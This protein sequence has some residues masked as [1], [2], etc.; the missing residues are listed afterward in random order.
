MSRRNIV[1]I[2][3]FITSLW[4]LGSSGVYYFS[5]ESLT[6]TLSQGESFHVRRAL[7]AT[8][9]YLDAKRLELLARAEI[10]KSSK[11]LVSSLVQND[12]DILA[13]QVKAIQESW[14]QDS[15]FVRVFRFNSEGFDNIDA[16]GRLKSLLTKALSGQTNAGWVP[17]PEGLSLAAVIPI[18]QGGEIL[19]FVAYGYLISDEFLRQIPVLEDEGVI[20][21]SSDT[22]LYST[23]P[24]AQELMGDLVKKSLAADLS[25]ESILYQNHRYGVSHILDPSGQWLGSIF[26]Q[27]R[28]QLEENLLIFRS[29]Y[30]GLIGFGV[31]VVIFTTIV[32]SIGPYKMST[33]ISHM[34]DQILTQNQYPL[35]KEQPRPLVKKVLELIDHMS[36]DRMKV[37]IELRQATRRLKRVHQMLDISEPEF[38]VLHVRMNGL[39]D[40][41]DRGFRELELAKESYQLASCQQRCQV[42]I[43]AIKN[44]AQ[45]FQLEQLEHAADGLKRQL[46]VMAEDENVSSGLELMPVLKS[47]MER[48]RGIMIKYE[49]LREQL[50]GRTLMHA[51]KGGKKPQDIEFRAL[52]ED[53]VRFL[54][55]PHK[56]QEEAEKLESRLMDWVEDTQFDN[57]S[58]YLPLYW[59]LVSRKAEELHKEVSLVMDPNSD[60]Q[61]PKYHSKLINQVVVQ[62]LQNAIIH[63]IESPDVRRAHGKDPTG[64]IRISSEKVGVLHAITVTDDGGGIDWQKIQ[65]VAGA[66]DLLPEGEELKSVGDLI[67]EPGVSVTKEARPF[68]GLGLDMVAQVAKQ[69]GGTVRVS[70]SSASGVTMVFTYRVS[71]VPNLA[72]TWHSKAAS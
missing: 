45:T 12:P 37:Q 4:L 53:V 47:R 29:F 13:A 71:H 23:V 31:L 49:Q 46:K 25:S 30:F 2:V 38:Q 43:D 58:N 16:S 35:T 36:K 65:E 7:K 6:K 59:Q 34:I 44:Y 63:G 24:V 48:L 40:Q 68:S 14:G 55:R 10:W 20:L 72:E 3:L 56:S 62:L 19:G 9:M 61:I 39:F 11:G 57:L 60:W 27:K 42:T 66:Q 51:T 8:E 33:E 70:Q 67:F 52:I 28:S 15:S 26:V 22:E 54:K 41:L 18:K 5:K 69:M 32:Y 50:V 64:T 1:F 21:A 17:L